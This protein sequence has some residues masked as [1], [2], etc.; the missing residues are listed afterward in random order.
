MESYQSDVE[1]Y[2]ACQ[3]RQNQAVIDEYNETVES[4]NRRARGG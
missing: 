3:K 4:F 2:L 1:E